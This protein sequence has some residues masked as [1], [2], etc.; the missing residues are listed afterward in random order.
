MPAP[1]RPTVLLVDDEPHSLSAMTMALE[2]EF[3]V[4]TAGNAEAAGSLMQ[5][6]WVQAIF[7]DQR[8]PGQSG[9]EFLTDVRHRWPECVRII[10][11][12]Y[13]D[14]A[15]M[16]SAINDAGIYQFLTKPW[17]PDQ[18]L[19]AARNAT[20]LFQLM[21]EH[22]R[23]SLELRVLGSTAESKLEKRRARLRETMGF[24]TIV[25]VPNSPMNAVIDIA[26]HFATYDVPVL[27]TGEPGTGKAELARAMHLTSLRSDKPFYELDCAGLTDELIELELF[28]ARRGAAAGAAATKI[29]LAQ[30]ADRGTL[31]LNGV[32]TLSP[33]LQLSL[34][35][36]AREG[37][38][39]TLGGTE[40]QTSNM[41]LITGSCRDLRQCV[42][43]GTFRG[44]LY[45]ALSLGTVAVPPLRA[46]R[47]DVAHLAQACLADAMRRHGKHVQGLDETALEFL[48]GYDWPGNMRELQNEVTRML[49]FAQGP[50]V[51]ADVISR[52][53]LQAPPSDEG[54][55]RLA[56]VG[57]TAQ[58][59]LKDR[60]ELM[61]MRILRETLTRLRWN[62]SHA[63]AELGLSRVGLRAKL[64]R[65]GID[66]PGRET[67]D[68]LEEED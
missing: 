37:S 6:N 35:R 66:Q 54:A 49:I 42:A 52:H 14:T 13:T 18:L 61:E 58:G 59:S 50:V 22:E 16:I 55:D 62:K 56:D 11:T 17:H 45:Y 34:L 1:V 12:G 47:G 68:E 10:I 33:R 32:D 51:G 15:D 30:K 2:D 67:H 25:R 31:F 36:L 60:V 48:E 3:D 40:T 9:V 41:R 24:E 65:Y 46:R 64:D 8:M 5:D 27:L 29:G 44:D 28:G 39:Q 38:F 20:A 43:D 4:L 53:I 26:R 57:L 21:R 7:C 63:A 19:I 23:L